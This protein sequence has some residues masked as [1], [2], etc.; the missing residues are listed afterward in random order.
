MLS[1]SFLRRSLRRLCLCTLVSTAIANVVAIVAIWYIVFHI[2]L[3]MRRARYLELEYQKPAC[4]PSVVGDIPQLFYWTSGRDRYPLYDE[5]LGLN[6]DGTASD[7][8][9]GLEF[10][11]YLS[12][13]A[14]GSSSEPGAF[15]HPW[16]G[17]D[18]NDPAY[19]CDMYRD[20]F[21]RISER[22]YGTDKSGRAHHEGTST[23][24]LRWVDCDVSPLLCSPFWGLSGSNLL[25]HMKVGEACDYSMGGL[26]R[27][28]ITWRWVGLPVYHPPWTRQ[29]RIPL[30]RGGSTVV[31]AFPSAEEQ[32]W[33]IMAYSGA[34][35]GL[36]FSG[37]RAWNDIS[38]VV[39]VQ[40]EPPRYR[41]TPPFMT[42]GGFRSFIDNPWDTERWPYEIELICYIERYLDILLKW[43]DDASDMVE[44]RSC[45][46]IAEADRLRRAR[47]R[48]RWEEKDKLRNAWDGVM[49]KSGL[50]PE[51]IYKNDE[52][53][54]WARN[55]LGGIG[56]G[57]W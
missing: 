17:H 30:D 48:E 57:F 15:A 24:I 13:T 10:W 27:C 28:P 38:T 6:H 35:Q 37:D 16:K 21:K 18:C 39:P 11:V 45:V 54:D 9:K 49:E 32:M 8:A 4:P 34:E 20:A 55:L 14:E 52:S 47:E 3:P 12:S 40:G 19:I 36:D 25:V 7:I 5:L 51:W 29:I 50:D 43:W 44:P 1:S 53:A 26:P 46:G 56:V 2:A 22:W 41:S 31:P 42:W 23:A 33:S